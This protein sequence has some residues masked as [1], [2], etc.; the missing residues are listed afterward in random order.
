[1]DKI[2]VK[3]LE[4]FANHGVFKE[5]KVL[6]QKF[7]VDLEL[8]TDIKEAAAYDDLNKTINYG[9]LSLEVE[10]LL[11][12]KS[13]D[14]IETAADKVCKYILIT[15]PS[16]KKCSVTLKKPFAPIGRSVKYA[17]VNIQRS[18]HEVYL[19]IGSNIGNKEANLNEAIKRLESYNEI[20]VEKKST[21]IKTE[22]W[23]Y[24]DQEEFLNGAL[25]I[26]TIFDERE[27]MKV[28]LSIEKDMK[29]ERK[30][31]WGPRIIDLDIIFFDDLVSS[32]EFVTLPHPR[33]EEREF[34]LK[35]L[36]EIAP[37]KL[38]PILKERVFK[39]LEKLRIKD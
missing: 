1:M 33:M 25:K 14:L 8:E 4:I 37:F 16:V 23:G 19:S 32:D 3:D 17:A 9:A 12:E 18:S 39:L 24:L 5:E 10:K 26:N 29:R 20:T 21:F 38:H 7:V 15:Y 27:L 34:V 31:K 6:G 30:V 28:L 13:Y 35:P 36:N 2:I 11:K 22:P